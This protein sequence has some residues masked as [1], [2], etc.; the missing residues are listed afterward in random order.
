MNR[1]LRPDV[2]AV[3]ISDDVAVLDL[4]SDRYLCLTGANT[5]L[6][7][8]IDWDRLDLSADLMRRLA[9]AGVLI[10]R[11]IPVDRSTPTLPVRSIFNDRGPDRLHAR[12]LVKA[13]R[14][15]VEVRRALSRP[16][17][18]PLLGDVCV[19]D[20]ISDSTQSL[21]EQAARTFAR[22]LPWLPIDGACLVRSA[23]LFRFLQY[24]GLKPDWVFGVRL[25]P[26]AAH[27][28]LQ[29]GEVCLNDD[30]DR[31]APYTPIYRR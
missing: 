24:H 8:L 13:M 18:S 11:F 21:T 25:W 2:F 22:I 17:V 1:F 10:D 29:A 16:G 9:A 12:D 19:R 27:C 26:F 28:W 15:V 14:A 31:L 30:A 20:D 7:A 5:D 4:S 6:P 23:L 3:T